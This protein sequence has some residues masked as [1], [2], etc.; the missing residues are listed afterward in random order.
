MT[1]RR[2]AVLS[3]THANFRALQAVL[4]DLDALAEP[5]DAIWC[6]GD[7]VGRGDDPYDVADQMLDLYTAQTPADQQ[8]WLVGNHDLLVLNKIEVAYLKFPDDSAAHN[9]TGYRDAVVETAMTHRAAL[10][11]KPWLWDD[12]LMKLPT[13]AE[14]RPGIYLVHG[15]Y[16]FH[17]DGTVDEEDAHAYYT[18]HDTQAEPQIQ[19]L[20]QYGPHRPRLVLCGHTHQPRF[21]Q[22]SESE[23]RV[24]PVAYTP[25]ETIWCDDLPDNPVFL[26]VGSVGDPRTADR[27]PTYVILTLTAED[28]RVGVEFRALPDGEGE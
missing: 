26:N 15:G 20:R 24:Y 25:G 22:W 23:Q 17:P 5:V 1:S 27:Q 3:D 21:W 18:R 28:S 9:M 6:L 2:I 14:V 7:I 12:W 4:D 8:G 16:R 13:H 19:A 11:D 10:F